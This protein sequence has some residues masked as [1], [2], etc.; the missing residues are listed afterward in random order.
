MNMRKKRRISRIFAVLLSITILFSFGTAAFA[1][2]PSASVDG[3]YEV[4]NTADS[5]T[6]TDLSNP[7]DSVTE[8]ETGGNGGTETDTSDQGG[9]TNEK[10]APAET[11]DA[12]NGNGGE[13]TGTPEPSEPDQDHNTDEKDTP[14]ETEDAGNGNG[15]E[16]PDTP[17]DSDPD[18]GND[19]EEQ[20]PDSAGNTEEESNDGETETEDTS[21]LVTEDVD[22]VIP[23]EE[24]DLTLMP[25]IAMLSLTTGCTIEID[26]VTYTFSVDKEEGT[27]TLTDME[28][29][30]TE[31]EVTVPETFEY[32]G[33]TYTVTDL[34]WA[35]AFFAKNQRPNVVGL[36]LPN[37]LTN[38]TGAYFNKFPS[39]TEITIP[40]SVKNFSGQFQGC[41]KLETITFEDGVEEISS[42]SMVANCKALTTIHLPDSLQTISG[43]AAFSNATA[44]KNITLPKDVTITEGSTFS[45]CKALEEM[46]LP[47]SMTEI[48]AYIFNNCTLLTKVEAKGVITSVGTY[49]FNGCQ[50]L[51]EIPELSHVSEMGADAFY[52]CYALACEVDLS[53]LDVIPNGAFGYTPVTISKFSDSLTSIGTYAF[54]KSTV[55]P[56]GE[57]TFTFPNTLQSIGKYAFYLTV[58]P[59]TV[60]IPDSVTA[61]GQRAFNRASVKVFEIGDGLTEIESMAF[62]SN[63]LE[64]IIFDNSEDDMKK[65]ENLPSVEI[66]YLKESIGDVG[67]TISEDADAPTLQEAV[68]AAEENDVITI[69][70]HVQLGETL[71][72]PADKNI[73]IQ[74]EGD[75]SIIGDKEQGID[76][77]IIVE[78]GAS[79][80]FGGH[81]TLSGRYNS[82]SILSSAGHV[83]LAENAVVSGSRLADSNKG[84]IHIDGENASFTMTGGEISNNKGGQ[85]AGVC[86]VDNGIQTGTKEFHTA[87]IMKGGEITDNQG[88]AA[89][90]GIY[91]YSNGVE[92]YAGTISGNRAISGGGIYSE[93]NYNSYSTVYLENAV[94]TDN[95]AEQGG[96]MWLC[97]TGGAE[98]YMKDGGA[99]YGN[100]ASDAGDDIAS[101]QA[102]KD[103]SITLADRILGGGETLW[104]RDGSIRKMAYGS[105]QHTT[106]NP[107]VPRYG[108]D[109]AETEPVRAQQETET[110][111][112]KAIVEPSAFALAKEEAKLFITDNE[113]TYGG[114][115]GANGGVVIGQD[116]T[117]LQNISVE[118][119]WKHGKNAAS[120][121]PTSVIVKLMLGNAVMDKLVLQEE[122]EWKGIFEGLPQNSGYT[123]VEEP[124]TSYTAAIAGNTQDGFIVTNTYAGGSGSGGGGGSEDST[125]VTVKKVWKL[126]NGGEATDSIKVALL[127]NGTQDRTVVLNAEKNW[128]HTWENLSGK[129]TWTVKEID[130]PDGFRVSMEQAGSTFIITNDDMP[131]PPDRTGGPR[132]PKTPEEPEEPGD[133]PEEPDD[134]PEQP[135]D[136]QTKEDQPNIEN[137]LNPPNRSDTPDSPDHPDEGD[138]PMTPE[139]PGLPQTGQMWWP[140]FVLAAAGIVLFAVGRL[141]KKKDEK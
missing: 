6:K 82:G 53:S 73:T 97:P 28:D 126:D 106:V 119:I 133:V 103:A 84:V 57:N 68:D 95:T 22:T 59:D 122:N 115:I 125:S 139:Q 41:Q 78:E 33:E 7:S 64:K 114:G 130:V 118:K 15:G 4:S 16:E 48:P 98:V 55:E 92:L 136:M 32:E 45:G 124:V 14:A 128:T 137:P 8:G 117:D 89:G 26:G 9:N 80:T 108:Q 110:F 50:K 54:A 49:A 81:L 38:T 83:T 36:T 87:F 100:Q 141:V 29:P 104:F 21:D 129:D 37:T 11:E 69:S 23:P 111:V 105:D 109:G 51:E 91:S 5:E 61:V 123:V 17:E 13:E 18:Q 121:Y 39:L 102:E 65:T 101:A 96:G 76:T 3:S 30:A 120:K 107:D 43:A 19:G 2:E 70:K 72:I 86:V 94:I 20:V 63:G 77:L 40:G 10:D 75:W 56:N 93:G 135:D 27:A 134:V 34:K 24:A 88:G 112:V 52:E 67:D 12:G 132:N 42:N 116:A 62:H 25:M 99:I 60:V 46:I 58:F 35:N 44:L 47:E 90:G 1:E 131:S 85:G 127:R 140:V 66:E 74:S 113:A 138:C 79:V 71:R 31:T